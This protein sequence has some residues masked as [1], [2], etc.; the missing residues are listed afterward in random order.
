MMT[1]PPVVTVA[2]AVLLLLYVK[3]PPL[4]LEG[5]VMLKDASP[6]FLSDTDNAWMVGAMGETTNVAVTDPLV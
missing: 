6:K 5:A 2:T 3:T 4:L 1:I